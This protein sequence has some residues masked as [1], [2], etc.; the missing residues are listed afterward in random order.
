[1]EGACVTP[2]ERALAEDKC[3]ST[4]IRGIGAQ[5]Y[6][7]YP[8]DTP[9]GPMQTTPTYHPYND[10]RW[11]DIPPCQV[12]ELPLCGCA[13][14]W[15]AMAITPC[16]AGTAG[17]S[18]WSDEYF[19]NWC[20]QRGAGL[21]TSDYCPGNTVP[22]LPGCLQ[23]GEREGLG[24][25]QQ[26]GFGGPNAYANALCWNAEQ[27]GLLW[28]ML[29]LPD[30]SQSQADAPPAPFTPPPP[31][32]VTP[33]PPGTGTTQR[34]SMMLPGLLLLLLAGGGA[35]YYVSQRKRKR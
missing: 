8:G 19:D 35:A 31:P 28:Q 1:M 2:E 21:L 6:T 32:A 20:A 15:D 34:S 23:P 9:F 13:S 7:V 30:C 25:C 5:A 29:Q 11:A 33:P 24:Y 14:D 4:V 3:Q 12:A 22:P 17:P 18:T 26:Y 10:T 16:L 27:S